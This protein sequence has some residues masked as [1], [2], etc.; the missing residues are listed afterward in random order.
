MKANGTIS[1]L[2]WLPRI[3]AAVVQGTTN[4]YLVRYHQRTCTCPHHEKGHRQCKHIAHVL[5]KLAFGL[6][7]CACCKNYGSNDEMLQASQ[8]HPLCP[9]CHA[10]LESGV[11]VECDGCHAVKPESDFGSPGHTAGGSCNGYDIDSCVCT[12]CAEEGLRQ[13][14]EDLAKAAVAEMA[15]EKGAANQ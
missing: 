8:G 7:Q 14:Q 4:Q 2:L 9:A 1:V 3:D 13:V 5:D 10:G 6:A 11:T 15:A 12:E